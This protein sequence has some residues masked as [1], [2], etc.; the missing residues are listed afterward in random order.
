MVNKEVLTN[1]YNKTVQIAIEQSNKM[2]IS[3]NY[4]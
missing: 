3:N 1:C 2:Y 4:S